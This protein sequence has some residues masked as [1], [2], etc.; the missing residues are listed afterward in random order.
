MMFVGLIIL[1]IYAHFTF[2][3]GLRKPRTKYP[4]HWHQEADERLEE[5][6]NF[7]MESK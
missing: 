7:L 3:K 4:R 5:V 1:L 2:K 6:K